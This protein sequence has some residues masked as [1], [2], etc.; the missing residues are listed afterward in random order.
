MIGAPHNFADS[1]R[2][3]EAEAGATWWDVLYRRFFGPD[4][5]AAVPMPTNSLAQKCGIDRVV[6]LKSGQTVRVDEKLRH[7]DHEDVL[8][9]YDSGHGPG[10]IVKETQADFYVY[11]WKPSQRAL[12]LDA[13]ALKR[14]WRT[15]GEGWVRQYGD[16]EARNPRYT[17]RSC[18]VPLD[19]LNDALVQVVQVTFEG[20]REA[21]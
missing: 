20:V 5:V 7:T 11:V 17:S 6:I 18:P 2:R 19:V 10:W 8:L 3:S 4:F 16:I 21:R 13:Q 14:A 15:F 12:F 9:E 1:L